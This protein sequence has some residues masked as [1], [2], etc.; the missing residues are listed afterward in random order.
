V[1]YWSR[2]RRGMDISAHRSGNN[3][4]GWVAQTIARLCILI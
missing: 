2:I 3:L 1:G 4:K